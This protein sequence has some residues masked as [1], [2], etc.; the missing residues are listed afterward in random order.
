MSE[1][2]FIDWEWVGDSLGQIAGQ[3]GE[4][5]WLTFLAV[6][7][8]LL[9][10]FPVSLFVQRVRRLYPVA[11]GVAGTLYTIPSIAFM[12]LLIPFTGLSTTTAVIPLTAYTLLIFIRNIVT[13]LDAVSEDAKEAAR[14]MGYTERQL[15]WRV[16]VPLALP[17]I[18]AGV[19]TATVEVIASATLA[20]FIGGGGLG[21]YITRGFALF[22]NEILLV[23]AIPVA[24]LALLAEVGMGV[25]QRV[26]QPPQAR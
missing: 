21:I 7:I 20:A 14:A 2:P 3:L 1:R 17:V 8:G 10:A 4:H 9:I 16:E 6:A 23:G 12:G 11:A 22:R 25:L 13:G 15:R 18:V 24:L 19:R 5:V 26:V